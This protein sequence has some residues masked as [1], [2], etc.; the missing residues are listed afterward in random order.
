M[1]RVYDEL[2]RLADRRLAA[3]PDGRTLEPTALVHEVW[4]RLVGEGHETWESRG[5]FLAAAARSMRN[6][7]VDRA[8]RR[9]RDK[10]G[11]GRR[12]EPLSRIEPAC[13]ETPLDLLALDDALER[14]EARDP[15]AAEVV[16]LRYFAGLSIADTAR[17]LGVSHATVEREWTYARAWLRRAL[18]TDDPVGPASTDGGPEFDEPGEE[19]RR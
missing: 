13:E 15:R 18:A 8:R 6:I 11:G 12:P 9:A 4:L 2:R 10:R 7:L 16:H 19:R 5:R 1:P 14:L 3:A 17:A